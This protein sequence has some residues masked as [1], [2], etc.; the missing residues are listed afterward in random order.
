MKAS[1][2]IFYELEEQGRGIIREVPGLL[3][4]KSNFLAKAGVVA[5]M[6]QRSCP[7]GSKK[8]SIETKFDIFFSK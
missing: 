6:M 7:S 1:L 4:V 2:L 8:L 5:L 3:P